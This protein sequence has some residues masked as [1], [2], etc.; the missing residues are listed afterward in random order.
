MQSYI[1]WMRHT[2]YT[3][4]HVVE[5]VQKRRRLYNANAASASSSTRI[6]IR[7]SGGWMGAQAKDGWLDSR[8][9]DSSHI[10]VIHPFWDKKHQKGSSSEIIQ[11]ACAFTHVPGNRMISWLFGLGIFGMMGMQVRKRGRKW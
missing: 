5:T 10:S 9:R 6:R 7:S 2:A 3:P 4:L 1:A 8:L 11:L